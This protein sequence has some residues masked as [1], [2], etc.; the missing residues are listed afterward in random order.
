HLEEDIYLVDPTSLPVTTHEA[1]SSFAHQIGRAEADG[2]AADTNVDPAGYL[3]YG[4]WITLEPS[5]AFTASFRMMIDNNNADNLVV[6]RLSAI[7]VD[8]NGAVLGTHDVRRPD[9]TAPAVY[10]DFPL[11]FTAPAILR[12]RVEIRAYWYR[13]AYIRL[14]RMRLQWPQ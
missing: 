1:E 9:F 5:G 7:D 13:R 2:W 3:A 6:V 4:A 10:Q 14:D 12:H 11:T 8:A